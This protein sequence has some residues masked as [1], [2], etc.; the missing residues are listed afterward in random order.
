MF[1]LCY[2]FTY[3]Y[4]LVFFRPPIFRR[5]WADFR[6][7]LPHD[8]VCSEILHPLYRCSYVPP[9]N[10]RG[11]KPKF[12]PICG[13]KSTLWAP[14]FPNAGKIGKCKTIESVYGYARTSIPNVEGILSPTSA[15]VCPL[16]VWGGAGKLWI[17][18]TSAVGLWQLAT[19]CLILGVGI[20]D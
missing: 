4:F 19:R 14:P 1:W 5:P 11:E 17:D 20:R 7:T 2:L 15:I 18:I 9:K 8:A 3:F 13:P 16:G 10:L 6:E 12:W